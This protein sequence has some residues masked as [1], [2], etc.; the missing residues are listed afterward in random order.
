[1]EEE[2]SKFQ[3]R[4]EEFKVYKNVFDSSTINTLWKFITQG[5]I[6]GLESPIKIGKESNVFSALT[7]QKERVA[8]KIYR[9]LAADFNRMYEYL[10][11]DRR[12]KISKNRR[13]I[14]FT[15]A[16]REFMNLERAWKVNVSVPKPISVSENVL[17]MEFIGDEQPA[18]LL[19]NYR[20]NM[21][22]ICKETIENIKRLYQVGLVHGDLSEY[23]IL[24]HDGKPVIIDLSHA[25]TLR[26]PSAIGLLR[27][28]VKNICRFFNK[29]KLNLDEDKLF[30][31]ITSK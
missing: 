6:E 31:E 26:S 29:F 18:P 5:K 9:I 8:I 14:I 1:M 17:I 7:K 25:L 12:F 15:W 24:V 16:K 20:E 4:L 13:Q 10:A 30:N 11:P 22:K 28:D 2:H 23:N 3:K 19:K 27:R 21:G